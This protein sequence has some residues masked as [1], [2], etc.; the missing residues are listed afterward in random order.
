[1]ATFNKIILMGN[2]THDPEFHFTPSGTAV[3]NFRLAVNDPVKKDAEPLYIRIVVFNRQAEPCRDYLRRGS[4]VFV[5]GRLQV[6][7]WEGEDGNRRSRPEVIAQ[8]VQFLSRGA[9]RGPGM[10]NQS[11]DRINI[12]S[13]DSLS[14]DNDDLPF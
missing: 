5:E 6:S 3:C 1:M 2:L 13:I 4:P 12:D 7:S 10:E 9:E 8:T 14:D 11:Q